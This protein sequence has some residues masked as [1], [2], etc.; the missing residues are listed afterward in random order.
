MIDL[1][2]NYVIKCCTVSIL[3]SV[4]GDDKQSA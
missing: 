1:V 3:N 2:K 4:G